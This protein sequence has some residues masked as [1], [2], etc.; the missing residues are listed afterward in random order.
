[1][2]NQYFNSS[3]EIGGFLNTTTSNFT[4]SEFLTMLII[5]LLLFMVAMLFHMPELLFAIIVAP[6][7]VVFG[8]ADPAFTSVSSLML[9]VAGVML[10]IRMILFR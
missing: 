10:A 7:L 6:L 2:I 5:V 1:M 3:L 4:G 9:I 8:L